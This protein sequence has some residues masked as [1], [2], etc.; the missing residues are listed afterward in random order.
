MSF[1]KYKTNID[2]NDTVILYLGFANMHAIKVVK[3]QTFQTKFGALRLSNLVG[4]PYGSKIE[5][6]KG[7][8]YVLYPT[9]EL[10]TQNLPHRT[11]ILY[12]T[13]ISLVILQLDLKPGSVVVESGMDK[14]L[15][16]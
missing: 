1:K 12:S 3:G 11:Q 7:Y 13:D 9:P 16:A 6:P 5:C 15:D 4:K 14:S 8:L 2:E 10:W